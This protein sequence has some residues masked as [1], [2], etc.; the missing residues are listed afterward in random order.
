MNKLVERAYKKLLVAEYS[1]SYIT[2]YFLLVLEIERFGCPVSH[3]FPVLTFL[4][5][6]GG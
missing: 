6:I 3:M 1:L 5:N 4:D 2:A